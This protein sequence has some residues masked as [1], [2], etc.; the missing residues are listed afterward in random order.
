MQLEFQGRK[1]VL[2]LVEKYITYYLVVVEFEVN[3]CMFSI[4]NTETM[5]CISVLARLLH[6][7][8]VYPKVAPSVLAFL[9]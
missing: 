3:R 6:I 5:Q 1:M 9:Q 2:D 8:I 4:K 7:L